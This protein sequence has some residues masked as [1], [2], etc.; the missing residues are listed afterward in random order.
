LHCTLCALDAPHVALTCLPADDPSPFDRAPT[1][2]VRFDRVA[3]WNDDERTEIPFAMSSP[4][5]ILDALP[6]PE[7]PPVELRLFRDGWNDTTKGRFLLDADSA[8][9]VLRAFAEHGVEL[10]MDFDHGT[11]APAG[12]KRDV[13]GYIGAL[14]YRPGEGLF[15]TR[16]RWTDVGLRAIS[17]GR[18]AEG[19]PTLPEYRYLSPAIR[20][21]AE[22]RRITAIEPVALVTWPATKNQ[23]P[24]VMAATG[25]VPDTEKPKMNPQL[26]M[27]LGLAASATEN[28]VLSAAMKVAKERDEALAAKAN[29][30]A[31]LEAAKVEREA[32]VKARDEALV[33]LEATERQSLFD[34]GRREGKLTPAL[35]QLFANESPEKIKAFLAAAPV[36]EA[37]KPGPKPPAEGA[38]TST[39]AQL[40]AVLAKPYEQWTHN[41]RAMVREQSPE[42]FR[43]KREDAIARGA[44]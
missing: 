6:L 32:L 34:Q 13:P 7:A 9:L 30:N 20:F 12:A 17:P 3:L 1:R 21:D 10:A 8:A 19:N 4:I 37:L 44:L 36:I 31:A 35:E 25:P 28:D 27:L 26:L 41:E 2:A 22:S 38:P 16:V 24:I 11:F 43:A 39:S 15:A 23:P 29:A 5:T 33:R 42:T 40:G 14:D 18:D